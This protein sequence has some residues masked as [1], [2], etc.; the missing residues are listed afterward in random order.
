MLDLFAEHDLELEPEL[1]TDAVVEFEL[2]EESS[3]E[4]EPEPLSSSEPESEVSSVVV[5][6]PLFGPV[7]GVIFTPP[8][9]ICPEGTTKV[10]G[11]YFPTEPMKHHPSPDP[12][13]QPEVM[14]AQKIHP[15]VLSE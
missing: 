9:E 8:D 10:F 1:V 12:S 14:M 7:P 11:R 15:A 2:E 13:E 4:D 3:S 5:E 6:L